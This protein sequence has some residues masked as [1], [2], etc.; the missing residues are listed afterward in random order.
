MDEGKCVVESFYSKLENSSLMLRKEVEN[1]LLNSKNMQNRQNTEILE[2]KQELE[3][4]KS[5]FVSHVKSS[6]IT[7]ESLRGKINELKHE[8]YT[9]STENI[10]LDSTNKQIILDKINLKYSLLSKKNLHKNKIAKEAR[11]QHNYSLEKLDLQRSKDTNLI[12]KYQ[13]ER[14][15]QKMNSLNLRQLL[16]EKSYLWAQVTLFKY[17]NIRNNDRLRK[18]QIEKVLTQNKFLGQTLTQILIT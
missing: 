17:D 12:T 6:R 7:E 9:L 14:E 13:K 10:E 15:I 16:I 2:L 8:I 5:S 18:Q 1:K 4:L 3:L 11:K